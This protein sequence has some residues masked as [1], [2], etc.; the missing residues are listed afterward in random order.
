MSRAVFEGTI[1]T[2]SQSRPAVAAM[3]VRWAEEEAVQD[4]GDLPEVLLAHALARAALV[5]LEHGVQL[6]AD[7]VERDRHDQRERV[8]DACERAAAAPAARPGLAVVA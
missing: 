6:L 3:Q 8:A 5:V 7:A 2:V 4:R 1:V